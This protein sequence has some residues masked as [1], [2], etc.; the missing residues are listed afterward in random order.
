[1]LRG[2][3]KKLSLL[4]ALVCM[5]TVLPLGGFSAYAVEKPSIAAQGAALYD[6]SNGVFLYEKNADQSFYPASI[7]KIMTALLVLEN[8]SQDE[9]VVFTKTATTNLESGAVALDVTEG[10]EI[11]VRDCLLG[12]LLKSA[13]EVANGLAEHVSGSVSAFADKMN[14]RAAQLGCTGTHFANPNGLN[15][16]QHYT[17]AHDMALIGAACFKNPDFCELETHTSYHFPAT[18]NRSS[19]TDIAMGHKMISK[20]S[21]RHYDGILGGKTGYTSKAGNTLVTCAERNGVRLVAVILKSQGTH[22]DDTEKLLNYGF[23]VAEP[24]KNAPGAE[25]TKAS[26]AGP[27]EGLAGNTQ[28]EEVKTSEESKAPEETKAEDNNNAEAGKGPDTAVQETENSEEAGSAA[29]M[30]GPS[31]ETGN[32]TSGSSTGE[33][34]SVDSVQFV[35]PSGNTETAPPAESAAQ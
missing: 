19:G 6:A 34:V 17:T 20:A 18:I 10:D 28:P 29:V 7:T 5:V 9:T 8:C 24:Q 12:L 32:G 4:L 22:Y 1:M 2:L 3:K 14:A 35:S 31:A 16:S 30:Q 33:I 13:N 21:A 11:S 23:A 25:E 27:G 15:N 26:L